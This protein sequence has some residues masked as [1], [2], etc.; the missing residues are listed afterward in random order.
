MKNL[1]RELSVKPK[2]IQIFF[3]S[4]CIFC[5]NF[6]FSMLGI[7]TFSIRLSIR[8]VI[9]RFSFFSRLFFFVAVF[10]HAS[11]CD[12]FGLNVYEEFKWIRGINFSGIFNKLYVWSCNARPYNL[13]YVS[14]PWILWK[15]TRSHTH[16]HSAMRAYAHH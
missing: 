11:R 10:E 7:P 4:V 14:C 15:Y 13:W 3:F 16:T 8:I 1:C 6:V 9:I 5:I 2:L 12:V